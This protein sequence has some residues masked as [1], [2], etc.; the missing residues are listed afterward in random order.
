M[1]FI[2]NIS[3]FI[4]TINN[5]RNTITTLKTNLG[6]STNISFLKSFCSLFDLYVSSSESVIFK[7]EDI[8]FKEIY[9]NNQLKEQYAF[10]MVSYLNQ[11]SDEF[12]LDDIK[13]LLLEKDIIFFIL[14]GQIFKEE[15]DYS[16]KFKEVKVQSIFC[17]DYNKKMKYEDNSNNNV[18]ITQESKTGEIYDLCFKINNHLKFCQIS[19]FKDETDLEKLRKETISLDAIYF[20]KNKEGLNIGKI[21]SYSFVIIT[22]FKVFKDYKDCKE[23]NKHTFFR[24]KEH[25]KKNNFEFYIYNYFENKMYRYN[26]D[27]DNIDMIGNFF[28]I[29]KKISFFDKNLQIYNFIASSKRK[30]SLRSTKNDLLKP[31]K[32]YYQPNQETES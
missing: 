5:Q 21:D 3:Q 23:K 15:Y 32:A 27:S 20:D 22:S 24:M 6:I 12:R 13:G 31:F 16:K 1:A 30:I 29:E 8:K 19:V 28:Y 26:E 7:L 10:L 4:N 18:I 14:T 11:R 2:F 25:C 17:L 9:F